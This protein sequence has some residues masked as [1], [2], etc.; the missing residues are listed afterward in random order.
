M[1]EM[2]E[3]EKLLDAKET[4]WREYDKLRAPADAAYKKHEAAV[5]KV[6]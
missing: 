6:A 5:A 4:T 2:T 1:T 3:L